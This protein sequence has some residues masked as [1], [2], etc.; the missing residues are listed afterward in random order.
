M[1]S[2]PTGCQQLTVGARTNTLYALGRYWVQHLPQRA[3]EALTCKREAAK[4]L[5]CASIWTQIPFHYSL[6]GVGRLT[7]GGGVNLR[8]LAWNRW[9]MVP[10]WVFGKT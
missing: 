3:L 5:L 4:A 9:Q 2:R 10:S 7:D 8:H 6:L 1:L